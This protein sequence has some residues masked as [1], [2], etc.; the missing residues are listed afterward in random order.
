M[1]EKRCWLCGRTGPE[2]LDAH[3]VWGGPLRKTSEKYGAVVYLCHNR[4]HIFGKH[5][6]HQDPETAFRLR[7]E[8]QIRLME[9]NDWNIED[10][11]NVFGKSWI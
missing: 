11:I 1:N 7:Q 2:H 6:V 10:F 8:T 9:E 5:A 4:C 3:H